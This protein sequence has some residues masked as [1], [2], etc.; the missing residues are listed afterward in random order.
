[1]LLRVPHPFVTKGWVFVWISFVW[2]SVRT[3]PHLLQYPAAALHPS[4]NIPWHEERSLAAALC[5]D[6]NEQPRQK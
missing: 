6:D 3:S 1:L 2:I 5:R 4:A